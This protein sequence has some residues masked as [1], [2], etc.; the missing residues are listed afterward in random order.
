MI[1]R[2]AGLPDSNHFHGHVKAQLL[3]EYAYLFESAT[4]APEWKATADRALALANSQSDLY[5]RVSAARNVPW[6]AI[7]ALDMR[8]SGANPTAC[9]ANGDPWAK[10]TTHYPAGNGPWPSKFASCL[11]ALDDFQRGWNVDF[12]KISWNVPEMLY[13]MECFNGFFP[14]IEPGCVPADAS[15]YI[16]SGSLFQ[17]QKLY[18]RGKRKEKRG[19]WD[20]KMHGYFD[21]DQV[22]LELG[23]MAFLLAAK[24]S[25]ADLVAI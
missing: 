25:G 19:F 14:R 12:H 20:G 5:K 13:F 16:Y 23:C 6:L 8:E 7:A 22:D 11:W 1:P 17:G 15:G 2:P 3:L 21:P 4:I 10:V 9:L 18:S 24:A